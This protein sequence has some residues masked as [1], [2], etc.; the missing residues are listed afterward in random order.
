MK[1]MEERWRREGGEMEE[2]WRKTNCEEKW[3]NFPPLTLDSHHE[4]RSRLVC[5]GLSGY[6][7][8]HGFAGRSS[9]ALLA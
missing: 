7:R 6:E 9:D 8:R 1:R 3:T 2:R 4:L 5:L